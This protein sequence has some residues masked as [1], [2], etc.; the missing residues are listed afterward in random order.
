[1]DKVAVSRAVSRLL[2][3]GRVHR[4]TDAED[5]RRSVLELSTTGRRIYRRITPVLLDYERALLQSLSARERRQLDRIL[6]RL[7]REARALGPP[8]LG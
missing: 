1:M 7:T 6:S 3:A 4:R 8:R 2:E 5:R